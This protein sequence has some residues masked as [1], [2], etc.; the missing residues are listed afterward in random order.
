VNELIEENIHI[1]KQYEDES[2]EVDK[3]D[4]II[5]ELKND[6]QN[7][8]TEGEENIQ[9]ISDIKKKFS[10]FNSYYDSFTIRLEDI[11]D[12]IASLQKQNKELQGENARLNA[13]LSV[14]GMD[15]LTPRPDYRRLVDGGKIP[16][17]VFD[18]FG[19]AQIVSTAAIVEELA[20]KGGSGTDSENSTMPKIINPAI[21]KI[22][23]GG[24]RSRAGSFNVANSPL[25]MNKII[26]NDL[27]SP[28]T[29][30]GKSSFGRSAARPSGFSNNLNTPNL[31]PAGLSQFGGASNLSPPSNPFF[32]FKE[33]SDSPESNTSSPR[34][35][36][37]PSQFSGGSSPTNTY[38]EGTPKSPDG[39]FTLR[40]QVPTNRRR[41]VKEDVLD[42]VTQLL[43]YIGRTKD[44]AKEYVTSV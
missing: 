29:T 14:S 30:S 17:Q 35:D 36:R 21:S 23:K 42:S 31:R 38:S 18:S 7:I 12:K 33:K 13:S 32:D 15:A 4:K 6:K 43:A 41:E 20:N 39:K 16:F 26:R 8:I 22:N 1:N 19:R 9:K 3:R 44:E 27:D 37:S 28:S 24:S 2:A 34:D 25:R 11:K 5:E 10:S 40:I